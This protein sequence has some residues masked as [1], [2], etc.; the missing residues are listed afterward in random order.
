MS[1]DDFIETGDDLVFHVN[2]AVLGIE[3]ILEGFKQRLV[4]VEVRQLSLFNQKR[5]YDV[6]DVLDGPFG[7]GTIPMAGSLLIV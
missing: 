5:R 7:N 6:L 1:L 3:Q 2:I 4:E